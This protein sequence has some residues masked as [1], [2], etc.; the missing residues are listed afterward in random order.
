MPAFARA[1]IFSETCDIKKVP[2]GTDPDARD[3]VAL[4]LACTFPQEMTD[5]DRERAG[6]GSMFSALRIHVDVPVV[7][8]IKEN[9]RLVH[10]GVDYKIAKVK[11][12]PKGNPEYLELLL[13]EDG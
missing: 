7:A 11:E 6:L 4:D 2:A 5:Q 1:A 13:Q 3:D 8:T 10:L 12:H 9:Y